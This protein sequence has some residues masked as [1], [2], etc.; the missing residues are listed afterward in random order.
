[1]ALRGA[2][3]SHHGLGGPAQ[4]R[5]CVPP[6]ATD[7]GRHDEWTPT[8]LDHVEA[9]A[10]NPD[11]YALANILPKRGGGDVGRPG[12]NPPVVYLLYCVLAGVVGSHRK[13]AALIANP[14]CWNIIRRSA[15][16]I[17][18]IRLP[19]TPPTRNQC[20]YHRA[21]IAAHI[22]PL[23]A[24]FR[25]LVIGQARQHG[26]LDPAAP[27]S[28]VELQ[29]ATVA[30]GGGKVIRSPVRRATA[31]KWRQQGRHVDG[32]NFVQ[33]G[34]DAHPVFGT[35]GLLAAVRPGNTRNDRIIV[36]VRHVP[37]RGSGG[38]AGIAVD[39]LLDLAHPRTRAAR[40]VLRL[41]STLALLR[42]C[43]ATVPVARAY[44]G[45][46]DHRASA[47][48]VTAGASRRAGF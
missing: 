47:S 20:E 11:L 34:D 3:V 38:E 28:T 13:T 9:I 37:D 45:T 27:D 43:A 39:A 8:Q 17:G 42:P 26:C 41:R 22:E 18:T 7:A 2:L 4:R 5:A 29:R 36:D 31:D 25:E 44:S 24:R 12:V 46:L 10:A 40:G 35:K 33:G 19:R 6:R 21:R 48:I 16:K 32:A 14:H 1:M 23:L 30:A 15:R